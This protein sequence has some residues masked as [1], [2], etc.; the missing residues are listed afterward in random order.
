MLQLINKTNQH[1][2]VKQISILK[3]QQLNAINKLCK[4]LNVKRKISS[5]NICSEEIK[6]KIEN[7][8]VDIDN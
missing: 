1:K 4:Y 8:F 2:L 6:G 7:R 3:E 5:K